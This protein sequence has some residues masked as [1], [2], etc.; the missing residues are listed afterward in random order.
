MFEANP[1][2]MQVAYDQADKRAARVPLSIQAARLYQAAQQRAVIGRWIGAITRRSRRLLDL[3]SLPAGKA[4]GGRRYA[5]CRSVPI[6]QI[7]GSE[8]RTGDFDVDLNPLNE[9]CRERWISVA[10]A[11]LQGVALPAVELIQVGEVYYIRDGH[12]RIS[13]ARALGQ[14][15]IDAQVTIWESST[16]AAHPAPAPVRLARGSLSN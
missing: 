9:T 1:Y 15:E 2:M 4:A 3:Y 16:P 11:M 12:H 6:E 7:R 14:V 10:M 8:G 13:A 5:G